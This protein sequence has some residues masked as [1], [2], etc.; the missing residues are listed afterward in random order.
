[1]N[2]DLPGMKIKEP[3]VCTVYDGTVYDGT[4]RTINSPGIFMDIHDQYAEMSSETETE[5]PSV[6]KMLQKKGKSRIF[7]LE[8]FFE[9]KI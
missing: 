8:F 1:M 3:V 2:F 9:L 7:N 4:V 6:K 5:E